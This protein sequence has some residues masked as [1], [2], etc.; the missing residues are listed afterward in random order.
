MATILITD[1]DSLEKEKLKEYLTLSGHNIIFVDDAKDIPQTVKDRNADLVILDAISNDV[2]RL[3]MI[4]E[5]KSTSS[6]PVIIIGMANME[7]LLILSYEL[8]CDDY[9]KRPFSYRE[10]CLRC[11]RILQ[12]KAEAKR[13]SH[14][15]SFRSGNARLEINREL[16][17]ASI[18]DEKLHFTDT[19]YRLLL[20]LADNNGETISRGDIL[21]ACFDQEDVMN[22][23]IVD[24]HI[25]N[26][27]AKI[28]SYCPDLISTIRNT[29]YR[30]NAESV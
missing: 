5:I 18:N 26:I 4:K 22:E 11:D 19:E 10:M 1:H 15:L 6:C 23:R 14:F 30:F 27:R 17:M 2:Q 29:G 8:G 21:K 9:I 16:R 13:N 12:R 3:N 24:S 28:E 20:F 7:S 25:K